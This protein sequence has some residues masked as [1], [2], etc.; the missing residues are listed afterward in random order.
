[1]LI[2]HFMVSR[3]L[4]SSEWSGSE[5]E[6]AAVAYF[7]FSRN[8]GNELLRKGPPQWIHQPRCIWKTEVAWWPGFWSTVWI[9]SCTWTAGLGLVTRQLGWVMSPDNWVGYWPRKTGLGPASGQLGWVLPP[10][11]LA[12]L[13]R[14]VLFSLSLE[15]VCVSLEHLCVQLSLCLYHNKLM[16]NKEWH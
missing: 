6:W 3:R 9:G 7:N 5:L 1:M 14:V 2:N 10:N 8:P 15:E 11:N 4:W 13:L 12:L 16:M